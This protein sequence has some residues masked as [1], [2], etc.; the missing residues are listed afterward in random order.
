MGRPKTQPMLRPFFSYFGGKWRD[1]PRY[2]PAPLYDTIVEPFA[3]SA[4]YSLRYHEKKVILC[5]LDPIVAGVWRF[6]KASTAESILSLP[7]I[8]DDDSV[9]DLKVCQEAKWLIGFWLNRGVSSPRKRPSRW[10][11]DRI[12]PGSFWGT[13]VRQTIAS[14]LE[15]INHWDVYE[16]DYRECPATGEATWFIDPPYQRAGQHYRFD[17]R[18]IEY[19][20]LSEWCRSRRGQVI[21]CENEGATWLPFK[22]LGHTKTTRSGRRSAEVY[23]YRE[24][25]NGTGPLHPRED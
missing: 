12:R 25:Q 13:R 16:R 5:E 21:V 9:D 7:D 8:G 11:R 24:S 2:Y 4:G 15:Y 22:D 18:Q 19:Q 17:S 14:Q 3:G 23:W 1:T 6:L 20:Q 10:M